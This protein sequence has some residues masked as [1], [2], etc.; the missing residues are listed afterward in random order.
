MTAQ[1]ISGTSSGGHTNWCW[2]TNQDHCGLSSNDRSYWFL[3]V[4]HPVRCE[5]APNQ[6]WVTSINTLG[7][8]F[9]HLQ[10]PS[11][12]SFI[13]CMEPAVGRQ[14]PLEN[15]ENILFLPML[16]HNCFVLHGLFELWGHL[17]FSCQMSVQRGTSLLFLTVI[18]IQKFLYH[19]LLIT[20]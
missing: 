9:L 20:Y 10:L 7:T 8:P 2:R 1:E 14:D 17:D 4:M 18:L 6:K 12:P 13:Y 19:K 15:F 16:S 11:M 3:T 5:A